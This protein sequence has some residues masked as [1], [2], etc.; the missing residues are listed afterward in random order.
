MND[1]M[2][3]KDEKKEK[4]DRLERKL[5]SR[6]TPDIIDKGRS[7]L[8][9]EDKEVETSSDLGK[10]E[11]QETKVSAFDELAKRVSEA[12]EQKRGV[13]KKVFIGSLIF[14]VIA[15]G[16]AAFVF[17]GGVNLVSSRNVDIQV[18][19]PISIPGGQE[20]S[21]DINIIN[22][23]NVDLESASLL[24]EYPEGTRSPSDLSKEVTRERFPL[25]TIKS[26]E[27]HSQ[28][29]KAVFFGE[30][31]SVKKINISLEYRVEN[32]SALFYKEKVYELSIS[33]APVII[34]PTYPKEVNSNQEMTFD[35]EVASNSKDK[36]N[37]FLVNVEYP[38][39]FVFSEAVPGASFSNNVWKFSN[40][41]P[42]EKRKISIKGNIIGQDKE[43]R[44]FRISAGTASKD[45]ERVIA[46]PL[47]D[48]TESILVKKPFVGVDV[49]VGGKN[50]DFVTRG[51]T[52]VNADVVVQ[53]NLPSRLFNATV[54]VAFKGGAFNGLSVVPSNNGFF[55]SSNNTIFWDKRS[56]D[57]L[58]DMGPGSEQRFSFRLSP[59]LYFNIAQGAKPEI[60]MTVTTKGERVL[61]SGS[62]EQVSASQTR[63]ITLTTDLGLA[64]K[65]A[66]SLGNLENSGPIPPKVNVPTTYTV[67]WSISNSFNQVS[68]AEVRATLP[69]YVKWKGLSNPQNENITLNEVTNEVV[70][71]VGSI[72]PNTGLTS[73]AKEVL[74]QLELL[75]STSQIGQS[76]TILGEATFSG[77]DKAVGLR[78]DTKAP[79]V[80]TNFSGDPSFKAG[81]EIVVP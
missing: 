45:D 31:E 70:W 64:A 67:I 34:T 51:G 14:F 42:G 73:P 55:Q 37:D 26:G 35:I 72:L 20:V 12:T 62:V 18:A 41:T 56:V 19:G 9:N 79:A 66:R 21:L 65:S 61:D 4:L 81:N 16:I 6:N 24:V 28:N 63:K 17:L 15:V 5:Y 44:V 2:D 49:F 50:A 32:S 47:T 52:Q 22:N 1:T 3:Y 54:E 77:I 57:G 29:I 11:L 39:G 69:P 7:E 36:I 43:E 80:T 46:V 40:L 78:I 76:P 25:E 48:L 75:P 13:V 53:N 38:F 59:L 10:V 58:A 71:N 23:N 68:N 27:S 30:K 60:E 8:K 33:S 74:F